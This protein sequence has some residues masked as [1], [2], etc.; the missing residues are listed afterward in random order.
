M[1]IEVRWIRT[2][3]YGGDTYREY[4]EQNIFTAPFGN[5]T[6]FLDEFQKAQVNLQVN[7]QNG[8]GATFAPKP[9]GGTNGFLPGQQPL[10]MLMASYLG[11]AACGAPSQTYTLGGGNANT[12]CPG[13]LS[14]ANYTN[15]ALVGAT[16]AG[17]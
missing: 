11:V 3:N 7:L 1:S 2:R 17:L 14:A 15:T 6:N 10:P 5:S 4:G 12:F 9:G 13:S 16:P 8:N